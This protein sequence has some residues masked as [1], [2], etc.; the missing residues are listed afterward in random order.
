MKVVYRGLS[1]SFLFFPRSAG[2]KHAPKE[3]DVD[4]GRGLAVPGKKEKKGRA[5]SRGGGH[6]RALVAKTS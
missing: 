3:D 1:G 4:T 2:G 5:V 6:H